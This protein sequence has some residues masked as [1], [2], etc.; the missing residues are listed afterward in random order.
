MRARATAAPRSICAADRS[1][2]GSAR[3]SGPAGSWRC[4]RR[5]ARAHAGAEQPEQVDAVEAQAVA[6]RSAHNGGSTAE[7]ARGRSWLLPE[8]DS[9]TMPSLSRPSEKRDAAHRFD[10][11]AV[12][13]AGSGRAGPR[14]RASAAHRP[15]PRCGSSS[16]AQ[17]VA[18]QVEAEADDEDREARA[19]SPPTT[20]RRCTAAGRDHRAPFGSGGCAPRPRKPRPAAV[21]MMPAMSKR[22]ADDHRGQAHRHDVAEDDAEP[23]GARQPHRVRYS[24]SC[25]P[26]ASR[27]ARA[28]HR[29]A[30]R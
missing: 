3:I 9:P 6:P 10:A 20:G 14:P 29:A 16:V 4:V 23:A 27:R 1:S 26:S 28:A 17:A 7:D 25:A 5:A 12:V 13:R 2:P 11:A 8:P 18:E 24:R 21:R 15:L 30:R 22:D 19:W